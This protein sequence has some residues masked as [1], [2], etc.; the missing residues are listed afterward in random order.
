A[1]D[2]N[3]PG[4]V[5]RHVSHSNPAVFPTTDGLPCRFFTASRKLCHA[6]VILSIDGIRITQLSDPIAAAP[7]AYHLRP[8]VFHCPVGNGP[9]GSELLQAAT[10]CHIG[11]PQPPYD[12]RQYREFKK[13][14]PE[15]IK[16]VPC[17]N[18]KITRHQQFADG[19]IR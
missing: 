17:E 2:K 11:T 3:R 10:G 12:R 16:L 19:N 13:Q 14:L 15:R 5:T 6:C 4:W 7:L 8:C 18:P 9:V 1:N